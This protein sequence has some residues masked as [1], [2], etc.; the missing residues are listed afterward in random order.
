MT[1]R[2]SSAAVP[3]VTI[4]SIS[5]QP[6][7]T[8]AR[9][10]WLCTDAPTR[11]HQRTVTMPSATTFRAP[12]PAAWNQSCSTMMLRQPFQP[13]ASPSPSAV[14]TRRRPTT[15]QMPTL[16]A[17]FATTLGAPK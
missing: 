16:P 4:L 10:S 1:H 2:V 14:S 9:V 11:V 8:T 13:C 17:A 7:M 15:I 3:T 6:T 5:L 12:G